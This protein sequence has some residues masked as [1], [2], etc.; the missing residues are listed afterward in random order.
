[1]LHAQPNTSFL[2]KLVF[3]VWLR[4]QIMK[5]IKQFFFPP[6]CYFLR[7]RFKY[8]PQH[9]V[10]K[11]PLSV[12]FPTKKTEKKCSLWVFKFRIIRCRFY[13]ACLVLQ[14][15]FLQYASLWIDDVIGTDLNPNRL[16]KEAVQ[17]FCLTDTR[18]II[19]HLCLP[20][21]AAV[22]LRI[23]RLPGSYLAT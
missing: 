20:L 2:L 7:L 5:I 23:F 13:T 9:S 3:Y 19:S 18:L 10:F 15:A 22:Q 6:L 14:F 21:H 11:R 1:M 16:H 12:F 8:F 17:G 4:A